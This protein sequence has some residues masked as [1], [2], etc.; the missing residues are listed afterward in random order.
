M[1]PTRATLVLEN[2]SVYTGTAFGHQ[3]E[4]SGEVVF[5]TSHTGYQEILT[6]PSYAGQ[7]V[8]MTYPLIGNY[9][10]NPTDNESRR[11]WASAF[12]VREISNIYSNY[13]ATESL[14]DTLKKAGVLG[15]AGIDTRKLVREIREKGA[16][17]GF[18]STTETNTESLQKKAQAIPQMTGRDLVKTVTCSENYTLDTPN[19]RYHVAAFDYGIKTNILRLLQNAGCRVTVLKAGTT[20][21]EVIAL[22]PDGVFL[23]NGPGDPSA[24]D[25]A[26][27][28][29]RSLADYSRT[30]RPLPIFGICLGHQLLALAL[31]AT[32]YKLK[33]G[34]HGSNHPV[35]NM[36]TKSI[37]ITSQ[38]HGFAVSMDSL[39]DSLA[40]TH[41][42][43]YDNTVEGIMHSEL[44]CFS[45]QYHPEAAPGPHDSHYLFDEFTAMMDQAKN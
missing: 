32:T 16:M 40:M 2:G 11:I 18:I 39:P 34:H 12:I 20:A 7:M 25:Y 37:E 35:K 3:G 30:T 1:Q 17:R 24:V 23:S 5:N 27:A 41:L 42:N 38:N 10:F 31:G 45:V 9:G 36:A 21:E 6:D 4:A 28:A 13:E 26:I 33:F 15:L 44:P 14:D 8:L 19:A 29:I 22:K 43:L